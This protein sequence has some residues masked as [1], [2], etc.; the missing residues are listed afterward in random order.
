[1]MEAVLLLLTAALLAAACKSS[2]STLTKNRQRHPTP[3]C[4]A[5][6][7]RKAAQARIAGLTHDNA[8]LA[9]KLNM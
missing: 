4:K 1:M 2:S 6:H 7:A 8:V 5:A 3:A 9:V